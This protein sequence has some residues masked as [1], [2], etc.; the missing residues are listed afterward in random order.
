M[1]VN[2]SGAVTSTITASK[3][4]VTIPANDEKVVVLE[5]GDRSIEISWHE[6][7]LMLENAVSAW[8]RR[9]E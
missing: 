4:Y 5:C 7:F 2:Y 8:N 1:S 6:L 9:A 3:T